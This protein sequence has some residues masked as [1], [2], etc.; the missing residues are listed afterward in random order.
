MLEAIENLALANYLRRDIFAYPIVNALH[1]LSLGMLVTSALLMDARV[2][3][4]G[5][6]VP[7]G[8]AIAV[9]RPVAI[10]A[11]G[12]AVITGALL[13]SV[14]PSEYVGN[15]VFLTKLGLIGLALANAGFFVLGR[16]HFSPASAMTRISAAASILFWILALFAGRAIAFF[17]GS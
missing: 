16:R 11:L 15:P 7:L 13:F 4:A 2:L 3:G 6:Q 14:R 5:R 12:V 8:A 17:G 1:I 10:G 9:L